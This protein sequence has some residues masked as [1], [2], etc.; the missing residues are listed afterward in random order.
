MANLNKSS[1]CSMTGTVANTVISAMNFLSADLN[2]TVVTCMHQIN[3]EV[4]DI[5]SVTQ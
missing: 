1:A 3:A 4:I 2:T 5:I